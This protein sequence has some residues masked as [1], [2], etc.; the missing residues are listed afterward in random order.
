M[1]S[2]LGVQVTGAPI[3]S[4]G[5]RL[6]A[7]LRVSQVRVPPG[8]D[9]FISRDK[10]G[11]QLK[12]ELSE[13]AIGK[14]ELAVT[15]TL[16]RDATQAEF[17]VPG[18]TVEDVQEQRGQVAI[19]LD[20]DLQAVL[21]APGGA[22]PID[23]AAL[24]GALRPESNRPPQY[25]FQYAAPP[26]DLRLRLSSAPSRVNGEVT[27][28]VSVREGAV[29]Y[30]SKVDFEI[31]QAGRSRFRIV[32]PE[33]LG[34]DIEVQG[35]QIR[36]IR[37]QA[38]GDRRTWEIELQQPAR[39]SYCL[40]L[41]QTLP[42]PDD[43]TVPAA[44]IRPLDVERS[45]SHL[46]LEN[47]TADEIA[48]TTS[49][50]V[51]PISIAAVPPGL[52]DA[53]RRQ[54]VAA[55][56]VAGEAA[57]LV[58][59]RRVREQ[60][61]SLRASINLA[62]LTTVIHAD[63]HYRA[64]AAYNVHN[65]TLQFLELGLPPASEVWSVLVSDQPVHPAKIRR[66]GRVVTLVPLQKISAGDFSSKVVVIYSGYLGEP[67]HR[68]GQVR[69]PAPQILSNIPVSRT[70][71]TVL[72]PRDYHVGLVTSESNLEE[73]AAEYQ[74]EERK[75]S[76]LD[77]LR[78]MV[79]VASSRGKSAAQVKAR[80]NLKESGAAL[81][82][83][84]QQI[85]PANAKNAVDVQEQAQ[86]IQA[87]IKR[88]EQVKTDARRAGG[89]T[90]I[91]FERPRREAEG[92][93]GG[94]DLHRA[95]E[96]LP[97]PNGAGG[98]QAAPNAAEAR[99]PGQAFGRQEER[100]GDLRKQAVDQLLRLQTVEQQ[101][102]AQRKTAQ[103]PADASQGAGKPWIEKT[104]AAA[105][106]PMV[107]MGTGQFSLDLGVAP[108]G[109]AHHFRKLHGD[110][111]LALSARHEDLSRGVV[112]LVWAALCLVLATAVIQGLRQ[113][114]ALARAYR[115]WPWLAALAGTAWLFLLPAGVFGLVLLITAL[116]VLIARR[117]KPRPTVPETSHAEPGIS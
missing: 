39:G 54:A 83:Y 90:T 86:Q 61:S 111:R 6:P 3:L 4:F 18:V 51:V 81:Y 11:Q 77:E 48:A 116:C 96:R 114:A 107:A 59:Q 60:E 117:R 113:P 66:Q 106:V 102:A 19:Y 20:D 101:E 58:W 103:E 17:T 43:G 8:A 46:V 67:L 45:R 98:E 1:R 53:I 12:M 5:I 27:T 63:G 78:Q 35:E 29:A 65:L 62:D 80:E 115:G 89:E 13:P 100:R 31:R 26:K 68:W 76:F 38:T 93:R 88:L 40:H 16:V 50:D 82:G 110:P 69:P 99:R 10:Q 112:A 75:L 15:G 84:A 104:E 41:V 36:Q 95:F 32:T 87:E 70:L 25:A 91:Y 105:N 74:Q 30:I 52:A 55:Y 33:W 2:L 57:A 42:L 44:I 14:L 7:A 37:S 22:Q 71:W 85:A 64:R 92:I 72:L 34:D 21:S 9:W 56:R 97:E 109:T 47:V 94:V 24:D 49:R 28:V 23:P 73:V 108:V 79:Q